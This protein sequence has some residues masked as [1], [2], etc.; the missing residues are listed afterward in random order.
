MNTTRSGR[1]ASMRRSPGQFGLWLIL[2]LWALL[3]LAG[4]AAAFAADTSSQ[5]SGEAPFIAAVQGG[6]AQQGA[7]T[8]APGSGPSETAEVP[9]AAATPPTQGQ[10]E[11]PAITQIGASEETRELDSVLGAEPPTLVRVAILNATGKPGGANKVAVLLGEYKRQALEDQIG[12]QIEVVNLSTADSVRAGRSV[13]FYRP[14]F[15][16]AA[17]AMAK[18]I[19]GDQFVEPMRPAGLKRA[20]VDVEIVVGQ[21]LP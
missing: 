8:K 5:V 10:T 20:G 21:E 15:L 17:L 18:A 4:S 12:M 3:I 13:L 11:Q 6:D 19:P 2:T 1:A 9:V 14:E 16:R 7:V